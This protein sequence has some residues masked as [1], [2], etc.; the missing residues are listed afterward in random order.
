M[1]P[2]AVSRTESEPYSDQLVGRWT[3]FSLSSSEE[4]PLSSSPEEEYSSSEG[5]SCFF[6]FRPISQKSSRLPS[7]R[8]PAKQPNQISVSF[9]SLGFAFRFLSVDVGVAQHDSDKMRILSFV[10]VVLA[11]AAVASASFTPSSFEV[12]SALNQKMKERWNAVETQAINDAQS[13]MPN[14]NPINTNPNQRT[15]L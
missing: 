5:L 13:G 2:T 3:R 14:P 1:I 6:F 11:L 9:A 4:Y 8:Q 10:L 7:S 15:R 12:R